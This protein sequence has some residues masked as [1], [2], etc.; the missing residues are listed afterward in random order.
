LAD[1]V[2]HFVDLNAEFHP[3]YIYQDVRE[4]LEKLHGNGIIH[5]SVMDSPDKFLAKSRLT[6]KYLQTLS[7]ARKKV[8]IDAI[9]FSGINA[10]PQV[11]LLSNSPFHFINKGMQFIYG[12][13]WRDLFDVIVVSA[14]KPA[15]FGRDSKFRR[16][17]ESGKQALSRVDKLCRGEIYTVIQN[18]TA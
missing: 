9:T 14:G 6:K 12:H 1:V 7:N 5:K 2:Q 10:F 8:K 16:V 3:L 15:W 4:A 11:F 17:E 18:R 13:D